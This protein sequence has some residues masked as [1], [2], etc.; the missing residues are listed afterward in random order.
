MPF[1]SKYAFASAIGLVEFASDKKPE[2]L[3]SVTRAYYE[4]KKGKNSYLYDY[5][6]LNTP[7]KK[8]P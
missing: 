1:S 3:K 2:S 7:E 4:L 5:D 6:T 8:R